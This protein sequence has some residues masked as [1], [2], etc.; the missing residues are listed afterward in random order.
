MMKNTKTNETVNGWNMRLFNYQAGYLTYGQYF[1]ADE[2]FVAR[3]KYSAQRNRKAGF[4]KFLVNNFTP[5][6]YFSRTANRADGKLGETPLGV[7]ES[8]GYQIGR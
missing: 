4:I 2:K 3:F 8:K 1:T 5:E 6:E 7:L